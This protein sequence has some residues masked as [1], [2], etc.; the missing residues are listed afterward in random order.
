MRHVALVVTERYVCCQRAV[1]VAR[2][3]GKHSSYALSVGIAAAAS[4]L[5]VKRDVHILRFA[6]SQRATKLTGSVLGRAEVCSLFILGHSTL[7]TI[8][9]LTGADA[10]FC[11]DRSVRDAEE[12][13]ELEGPDADDE[14][15]AEDGPDADDEPKAEDEPKADNE[16]EAD[17]ELR[18]DDELGAA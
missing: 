4:C 17:D 16:P 13:E 11:A 2:H 9:T 5:H 12:E 3:V 1:G 6:D 15:E 10:R 7:F 18:A 14:P 8:N